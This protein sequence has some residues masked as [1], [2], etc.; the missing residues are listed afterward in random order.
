MRGSISRSM[1][2]AATRTRCRS[3]T[4]A[5]LPLFL[6]Q[7]TAPAQDPI[8]ARAEA[9]RAHALAL[10]QKIIAIAKENSEI[11]ANLTYLSDMIGPRLTGSPAL[12]RANQWAAE[13]MKSY[14]LTAV[15][16]EAWSIPVGWERGTASARIIEPD[17]GR[18]LLLAAAGWTPS[19]NGKIEANLVVMTAKNSKELAAYKG[20]LNRAVVLRGPPASVRPITD[21]Q[22]FPT[23]RPDRQAE[24]KKSEPGKSS[25][26]KDTAPGPAA[27]EQPSFEEMQ[28]FRRELADFLRS[29]GA[30]VLLQ[31]AAKPHGL[32]TT[33]G[34]WRGTDRASGPEPLPSA[35]VAHEHYA[36]LHRLATRPGAMTRIEIEITNKLIPGPLAVYNTVGEIKGSEKPDE[37]VML[38]A[39][40]D[41]W[42]LAQGTTDNGTGSVVVLEAARILARSGIQPKRTIRFVLF[43]GEEQGL[44][45]SRAYV[46]K[47]KDELPRISMCLVHDTGTGKVIGIGLQGREVL[48]PLLEAE[49]ISLKDL[50]LKDINL[51][52]MR[53]TDHSSFEQAGVPGFAV[54][55]DMAEYRF[56]HHSQSDTLDK[57][58]EADLIQGAQVMAVGALR[59]ANL[60]NL[61]PRDR[62]MRDKK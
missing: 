14:G 28:A 19:T 39:H 45:G 30:A 8:D 53:G 59:V 1:S 35:F 36:L 10:D 21:T 29:E 47:H 9:A 56:T 61:L 57:A 16:L 12:K 54:Q 44:H 32:L 6:I 43:T 58:R 42:D 4:I 41:S 55:Q 49:L 23:G 51:R 34:G 24:E 38:G 25:D 37:F 31:D 48:R 7:S 27:A 5:L 18:A 22:F 62:P 13:K 33:T 17:N 52:R 26:K 2:V 3:F 60:P 50:G 11:M 15:E 46:Q 20:K 40:L